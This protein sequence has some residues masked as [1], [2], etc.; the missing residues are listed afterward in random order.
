[1]K[2]KIL[3]LIISLLLI[4]TFVY[5]KD[6]C[7]DNDIQIKSISLKQLNG[8]TEE[9]QES[10]INKNTIN[11]N[12]KMYEVGDTSTYNILIKN[13]SNEDY[14]F[15]KDSFKI[16][17]DYLEYDLN[18]DSETIKP[19]EE[20]VISLKITYKNRIS[21]STLQE[22]NN[23]K[24]TLS[25]E[26]FDNP[27]TNT[28]YS[29]ILFTIL[30]LIPICIRYNKKGLMVLGLIG[31]APSVYALCTVNFN[32]ETKIEIDGREAIFLPGQE[33]NVKMKELA[34]TDTSTSQYPY[35]VR[36]DT[37][38]SIKNSS[39]EPT[40]SEKQEKN[41]V[42][43]PDSLYPIYMWYEDGIIYWWSEDKHPAL[44]E[45]A[46][47]FF[48]NMRS[49]SDI[50]SLFVW[51][52]SYT[53]LMSFMFYYNNLSSLNALS[54]WNVSNTTSLA[55]MFGYNN[56]LTSLEPIKNWN[57]SNVTN[58]NGIFAYLRNLES[59]EGLENW[60]TSNVKNMSS[61][62]T[63]TDKIQSL[64]PI[65]NWDTS[66]VINFAGMFAYNSALTSLE[67]LS[68]WNTSKAIYFG[69]MFN[70]CISLTSLQGLENWNTSK[71]IDMSSMFHNCVEFKDVSAIKDW[72]VSN[73]VYMNY[74]FNI[75]NDV[76]T[77]YKFSSLLNID[78]S[79]WNMKSVKTYDWFLEGFHYITAEFT[80][81]STHI[82]SYNGML[83]ES[84]VDGGQIVV[85]YTAETESIIDTLIATKS[86]NGNVIKGK[87]VE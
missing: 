54:E 6:T 63:Y 4:P 71:V 24:I 51:D 80:V 72:D 86:Q 3:L 67:P 37:I 81:R 12:L 66:N 87:I 84:S 29:I 9:I 53:K 74:M 55:I 16:N 5:A 79:N 11:L 31:L 76:A 68:N 7:T 25:N 48:C 34:G 82:E 35:I 19:G 2:N 58:M 26:L 69:S 18:N 45:D 36:N 47:Y 43:T 30:L 62:F 46:S 52:T 65:R 57:T 77:P 1:M 33:V 85:N 20:K 21:S 22:N 10:S 38:T 70:H 27:K 28:N 15:T 17:T 8:F 44:N 73:V 78:I 59:L 23:L 39:V 61:T 32:I 40:E 56:S 13:T 64:E 60:D 49:L 83:H 75:S 14:Y 42:S 41:I 50:E